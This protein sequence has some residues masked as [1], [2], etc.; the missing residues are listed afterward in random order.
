MSQGQIG[1]AR[2]HTSSQLVIGN[3]VTRQKT[4]NAIALA[5]VM[6]L[7]ATRGR[8]ISIVKGNHTL[9]SNGTSDTL[10]TDA[11]SVQF[12]AGSGEAKV[13]L[14]PLKDEK[15]FPLEGHSNAV[16]KLDLTQQRMAG[17]R[18]SVLASRGKSRQCSVLSVP[19]RQ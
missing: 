1:W 4:S 5:F 19:C 14:L 11:L 16:V 17:N 10:P 13:R 9:Q 12:A 3:S 6:T 15:K 8:S 18:Y 7:S 2:A